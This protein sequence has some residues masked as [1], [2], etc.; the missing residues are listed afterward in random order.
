LSEPAR[1]HAFGIWGGPAG[2]EAATVNHLRY[3]GG[4]AGRAKRIIRLGVV[5][6]MGLVLGL[7]V[8]RCYRHFRGIEVCVRDVDTQPLRSGDVAVR[9]RS[10][11]KS[12]ALGD[13]A[14]TATACVWVKPDG[15]SSVDVT[16]TVPSGAHETIPLNGY[17]E[18]GNNGWISADVTRDGAR[19]IE[20]DINPFY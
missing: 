8:R 11:T 13:L 2:N 1:G 12:Y 9:T 10:S 18:P 4:V 3:A 7:G 17:I 5:A 16:F 20:E 15:E 14:P 6:T 19:T